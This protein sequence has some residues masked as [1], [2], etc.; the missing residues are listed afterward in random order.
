[1]AINEPTITVSCDKCDEETDPMEMCALAGGGW[2]DRY[3]KGKL[4]KWGWKIDGNTTI[5]PECQEE[6]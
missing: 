3:I 1:M 6:E 2:D 4:T 5:C